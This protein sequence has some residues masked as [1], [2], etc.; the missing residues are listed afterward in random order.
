M[1]EY[2]VLVILFIWFSYL[3]DGFI[4]KTELY[5][6]PSFFKFL[7]LILIL[8]FIVD[9]WLNGRYFYPSYIV[10]LYNK[11]FY[12]GYN[13]WHTP[14]ENFV[15]GVSLMWMVVSVF[16]YLKKQIYKKNKLSLK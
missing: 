13:I 5:K 9:N 14:V 10:G 11:N 12:L 8:Q 16:E 4:L 7:I 1:P 6:N 3:L 2:T 15:Y